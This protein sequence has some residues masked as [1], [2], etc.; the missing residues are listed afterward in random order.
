MSIP[1]ANPGLLLGLD[2][3]WCNGLS[4]VDMVAQVDM[5]ISG[6][7]YTRYSVGLSGQHA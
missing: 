7:R 5:A 3:L 1:W 2:L 4:G 6:W